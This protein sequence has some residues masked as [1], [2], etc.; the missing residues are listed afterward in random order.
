MTIQFMD[1]FQFYGNDVNKMLEGLPWSQFNSINTLSKIVADPDG[2]AIARSRAFIMSMSDTGASVCR[3]SLP[4]PGQQMGVAARYW[5]SALPSSFGQGNGPQFNTAGNAPMYLVA[6][7]PTGTLRLIRRDKSGWTTTGDIVVAETTTPVVTAGAWWH[8]EFF[9]NT[10]TQA[11][12]VRVE[13][14]TVL[15]GTDVGGH[16]D[17]MGIF[18]LPQYWEST[19]AGGAT[20]YVKDLVIWDGSGTVN[21]TFLGPV[22]VFTLLVDS[23]VSSGWVPSTG[24]SDFDLLDKTTPADG[25]FISADATPPAPSIMG[26]ENVPDDVVLIKGLQSMVRAAKTDSGDGW[27]QVAL[28]SGGIDDLGTDRPM[29]TSFKYNYDISE[30]D[31]ALASAWTP[32]SVNAAELKINRTL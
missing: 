20:K 15:S 31:P 17:L 21:N 13:G 10:A 32:V 18:V 14:V 3:L 29:T 19:S 24:T 2:N 23:D 30:L 27:M 6:M 11:Y 26:L 25:T 7:T 4:T 16:A 5:V 28:R 9:M 1:N 12:E 8:I 22:A